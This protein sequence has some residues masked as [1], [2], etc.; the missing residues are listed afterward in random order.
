M[1]CFVVLCDGVNRCHIPPYSSRKCERVTSSIL[2]GELCALG[3]AF[4]KS[5]AIKNDLEKV[6]NR[7]I[8]LPMF[9][10]AKSLFDVISKHS[11]IT[12]KSF[13]MDIR[14]VKEEYKSQRYLI[15]DFFDQSLILLIVLG[16]NR[17]INEVINELR[18]VPPFG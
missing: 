6:L 5:L 15:W 7:R 8:L 2:G 14:S 3:N 11:S 9:T 4:D 12:E 18:I 1:G 10:D 16:N 17:P 13:M